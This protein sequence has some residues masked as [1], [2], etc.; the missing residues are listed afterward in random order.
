M[1]PSLVIK[2]FVSVQCPPCQFQVHTQGTPPPADST[3]QK[4]GPHRRN[5][6]RIPVR[7]MK[8]AKDV[9]IGFIIVFF[10]SFFF[11]KKAPSPTP[12]PAVS[13]HGAEIH[14][15]HTYRNVWLIHLSGINSSRWF[16]VWLCENHLHY[17]CWGV[18]F[19]IDRSR[20]GMPLYYYL[21]GN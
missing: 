15:I 18:F 7:P 1:F 12:P 4:T 14:M 5:L 10:F 6:R 11:L 13:L 9:L 8:I 21:L 3:Q 19:F 2:V 20:N 17:Y 16:A